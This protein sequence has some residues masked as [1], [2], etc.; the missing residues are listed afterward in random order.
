[1]TC[2]PAEAGAKKLVTNCQQSFTHG[3]FCSQK[4]D[5]E[6]NQTELMF[7]GSGNGLPEGAVF[8]GRLRW[9]K[10]SDHSRIRS[11]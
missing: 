5:D 11:E 4:R 1:M 9:C 10:T 7:I 2:G 8:F 3:D 6:P